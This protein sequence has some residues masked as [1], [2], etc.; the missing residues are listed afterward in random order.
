MVHIVPAAA[1]SLALL[2]CAG[3]ASAQGQPS[4]AAAASGSRIRIDYE[5]PKAAELRTIQQALKDRYVL[6]TLQ[7]F[8]SPLRLP[9]DVTVRTAQC[10]ERDGENR[11]NLEYQPNRPVTICYELMAKIARIAAAHTADETLQR[12]VI[13]GAFVQSALQETAYAIFDVLE[14]PIWGREFDAA[15]R[16]AA[17]IIMQFGDDIAANVMV[18]AANLFYWSDQTWQGSQFASTASPDAQRFY[19]YACIAVAGNPWLFGG[20]VKFIPERRAGPNGRWCSDDYEEIRR[21][22]N[23]RIMP[24][25]D[26]DML[27]KMRSEK[28]L[29]WTPGK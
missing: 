26:A 14:I 20:W 6:E 15:D 9:R 3:P 17:F 7:H 28:W 13:V 5:Q 24:H 29:T 4:P 12:K 21:A 25:V 18:G 19:N 16:L 27:V 2:A 22:F 11:T 23:L 1:I 10:S 8:L